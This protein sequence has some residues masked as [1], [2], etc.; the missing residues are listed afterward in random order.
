MDRT[1]TFIVNPVAGRGRAARL[2]APLGHEL[3]A[4]G[5]DYELRVSTHAAEPAEI[6]EDAFSRDRTVV[7]CGGDGLVGQLAGVAADRRGVLG[8]VPLGAG[9][10]FARHLGLDHK[11]PLGALPVLAT[12][13]PRPVDLGKVDGR[14]YCCTVGSG[15]DAEANRWANS[16]TR[17]SGTPLYVASMLRTLATYE[18]RRFRL[19]VDGAAREVVAWLVTVC[20]APSYGGGMIVCPAARTD[21]GVLHATVVGPVSRL[22][23]LRT[24]PKVFKGT[25]VAHPMVE[26]LSGRTIT[27]EALDPTDNLHAYADG[28]EVGPL[29]VTAEAVPDAVL[30]IAPPV[31]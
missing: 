3:V 23:F 29:P 6:A 11:R 10:D 20:N 28:E 1:F 5:L 9:N 4:S 2:L 22:E 7:A 27:V 13:E 12:G 17:L 30:V 31:R 15:F 18:P 24:F 14:W 26:V 16:V 8:I 25:H 19:T 21:D